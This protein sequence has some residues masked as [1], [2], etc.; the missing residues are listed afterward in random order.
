MENTQELIFCR[1]TDTRWLE[2]QEKHKTCASLDCGAPSFGAT[3]LKASGWVRVNVFFN[4]LSTLLCIFISFSSW[5]IFRLMTNFP[6][7][8]RRNWTCLRWQQEV[9][10]GTPR[11]TSESLSWS[12][13]SPSLA[14]F[15]G[16]SW[17]WVLRVKIV[18]GVRAEVFRISRAWWVLSRP[19]LSPACC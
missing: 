10:D 16:C 4:S 14:R 12:P 15:E 8:Q 1:E 11:D 7:C 18:I 9:V 19:F 6:L 2:F 17:L 13:T 3:A 5:F